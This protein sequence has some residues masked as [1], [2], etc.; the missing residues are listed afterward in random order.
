MINRK[1]RGNRAVSYSRVSSNKD[2]QRT[3]IESQK[4]YYLEKF[5]NGGL[6]AAPVGVIC[7]SK[8]DITVT[9]NGIYAD[10]RD[11][12]NQHETPKSL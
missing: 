2:E 7:N 11:I 1:P 4:H 10:E 12:R 9:N 5:K 8:G 6:K 3:S